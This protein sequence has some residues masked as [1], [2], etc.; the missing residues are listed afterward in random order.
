MNVHERLGKHILAD[1]YPIVMDM[2]KSHGSWIVDESGDE[3]LDMFSMF[4]S[5]S[6][7]YNHPHLIKNTEFLGKMAV[8]KPTVSDIYSKEYADFVDTFERVAIPQELQYAFFVA[9]GALAVE[10]ALK[11]S[12]DWKTRLNKSKGID[13]EAGKVIHFKQAFHGRSGYTLSLTNTKDPRKH[14][15]FPKFDWP[16]ITNPKMFFPLTDDSLVKTIELEKEA[17]NQIISAIAE[18]PNEVACIIVETIQAEG[19]DNYFRNE[20]FKELRRICDENEIL[21][22]LDEV[23]TGIGITGKMW[24]FQNYDITPDIISF[25]KK[26]Q[27]CGILANKE[28]LDQVPNN[29]FQES[30]RINSTFGGNFIDMLRFKLILEVIEQ[31]NLLENAKK[32]GEFLKA[33]LEKLAETTPQMTNVRGMGLFV[34]FDLPTD[35]ERVAFINKAFENKLIL[36]PCGTQSV[37]FRPHLN[38]KR[39]DIEKAIEIIKQTF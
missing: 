9:G 35:E 12:F 25:G 1:G 33:E 37:R 15:Y 6:I 20:F 3:Y 11:A 29:V 27:V 7:G 28:K 38:V 39:E 16:R 22:I 30:S 19:G 31:E 17:V 5:G 8:N 2:E 21:L 18:S 13:L 10:N 23:Q 26:T 4:A 36:L 34:A 24:G 32:Q 14:M